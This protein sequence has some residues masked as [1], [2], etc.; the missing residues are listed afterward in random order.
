MKRKCASRSLKNAILLSV[1]VLMLPAAIFL[2]SCQGSAAEVPEYLV[3]VVEDVKSIHAPDYRAELFQ[4]ELQR[5]GNQI[6]VFGEVTD[7]RLRQHLLDS[8]RSAAGD[9]TFLDSIA[10]LPTEELRP[11]VYGIVCVSVANMRRE[12]SLR[13]ELVNQTLLGTV[14]DL[15]KE[16]DGF[17]YTRNRDRYLGWVDESSLTVVDSL[18]VAEWRRGS[19]VVCTA[20]YGLVRDRAGASGNPITDLVPGVV[21]KKTGQNGSWTKVQTPDGQVGYV[22]KE[23]V[24]DEAQLRS[25]KVDRGKLVS[26]AKSYLGIPY[27]WGGTSTKGFD[28]SGFVQTVFRMNNIHLP[29]DASQQVHEGERVEP[30]KNF[31]KVR[32]GDLLFFGS[33]PARITHVALYLGNQH[34]IHAAGLVRINSL[35]PRDSFYSEYRLNTLQAIKR[36]LPG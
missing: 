16:E 15:Y 23:L 9:I 19:R 33:T 29:R 35:N 14:L 7:P 30:G 26:L 27:L 24:I 36:V 34:Y 10:V 12:P 13:A 8:L 3:K 21:L 25:D 32:E 4:I 22:E 18:A 20:N 6:I 5:K 1:E 2:S 11:N 17:Y 28:C 31:E